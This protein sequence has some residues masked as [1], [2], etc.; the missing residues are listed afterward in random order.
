MFRYILDNDKRSSVSTQGSLKKRTK[1]CGA[2]EPPARTYV[3][4][5]YNTRTD[6]VLDSSR[7]VEA[8]PLEKSKVLYDLCREASSKRTPF[9][10]SCIENVKENFEEGL[11]DH[12]DAMKDFG[13]SN[14]E[15][16][17]VCK[18]L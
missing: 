7:S 15:V 9:V 1:G 3:I 5:I 4:K 16:L 2:L 8:C 6:R 17:S 12:L 18:L 13:G 14:C 11:T 10:I